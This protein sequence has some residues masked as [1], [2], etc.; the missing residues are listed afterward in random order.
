MLYPKKL[1]IDQKIIDTLFISHCIQKNSYKS[2]NNKYLV[3]YMFWTVSSL[4]MERLGLVV[5]G[6]LQLLSPKIIGDERGGQRQQPVYTGIVVN[7]FI[8]FHFQCRM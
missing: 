3:T 6:L 7:N 8:S 2:R 1:R 5:H 4:P